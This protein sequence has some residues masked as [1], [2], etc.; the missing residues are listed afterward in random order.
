MCIKPFVLLLV[1][2]FTMLMVL[3]MG[4]KKE[5]VC[6]NNMLCYV[7]KPTHIKP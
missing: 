5:V 4:L 1:F 7:P 3:R 6:I 2:S